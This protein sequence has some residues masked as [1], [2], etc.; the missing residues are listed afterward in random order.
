ALPIDPL[1]DGLCDD[2]CSEKY[3]TDAAAISYNYSLSSAT[4]FDFHASLSRFKYNRSPTN[5]G[6]D[7]TS[8]DWPASY[9][10]SVPSIMRTPPT[11]CVAN[12]AD[13][14]MCT[15]GQSFIQ[16]HDT[17]YNLAPSL[18]LM[19]GHHRYHFGF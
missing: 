18:T 14:I 15:Q 12:F 8:I 7:L 9:N 2:G 3:L 16:D 11:P 4:T 10:A 1:R 19:R 17:Q 5:A 13:S 6:F